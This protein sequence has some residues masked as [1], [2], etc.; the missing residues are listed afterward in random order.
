MSDRTPI[1][2]ALLG[3]YDKTGIEELAR[4]LTDAGGQI[5]LPFEPGSPGSASLVVI[6]DDYIPYETAVA[7]SGSGRVY[8]S[9][10]VVDDTSGGNG[11]GRWDGGEQVDLDITLHNGTSQPVE[12]IT[13]ALG[14]VDGG[15]ATIDLTV[16]GASDPQLLSLGSGRA[17]PASLPATYS[18]SDETL[19]GRPTYTAG[20][21]PDTGVYFWLD[22]N[23]WHVRAAGG[24]EDGAVWVSVSTDGQTM[25]A[26]PF[27]LEGTDSLWVGPQELQLFSVMDTTECEDGVNAVFGDTLGLTVVTAGASYGTLNAGQSQTQSFTVGSLASVPDGVPVYLVL[28][29][30]SGGQTW[31][32]WVRVDHHGPRL[33]EYY[34]GIDDSTYTG[35]GN[36][37]AEVGETVVLRSSILNRGSG[38]APGVTAVLRSLSG[39]DISD[40]TDVIGDVGPGDILDASGGFVFTCLSPSMLLSLELTD[41]KGR[42]WVES[43]ELAPPAAPTGLLAVPAPD[44]IE[45]RWDASA[46]TDLV[47]YHVYRAD[48]E[49]SY[50]RITTLLDEGTAYHCDHGLLPEHHYVYRVTA[51]DT[52]G[53]ESAPSTPLD[54]WSAAPYMSGFPVSSLNQFFSSPVVGDIDADNDLE[55]VIG[56]KDGNVYAWHHTGDLVSGWPKDTGGEVWS[57]PSL[58]Q[59][60]DDPELVVLSGTWNLG[61]YAWNHDGSG[62]LSPN[63]LFAS[64]PNRVRS[65]PV[66]QDVDFDGRVEVFAGCSNGKVYAWN[67]DGTGYINP[68]GV[69]ASL[70]SGEVASSPAIADVDDDG[71]LEIF[72]GSLNGNFYGWNRDGTGYINPDGLFAA[73]GASIWSS[74]SI[75]DLDNNGD[76]EIVVGCHNDSVYAWHHDGNAMANW[77]RG[78][79]GEVWSSPALGDLDHDG[80]LEIVIGSY[81]YDYYAWHH[82]GSGV[83]GSLGKLGYTDAKIW[84]SAALADIDE[85]G[86]PDI[87]GGS[88]DGYLYAWDGG[89]HLLPGWPVATWDGIYGSPAVADLDLDGDLDVVCASYDGMLYVYDLGATENPDRMDWPMFRH[90]AFRTGYYG[91]VGIADVE[92]DGALEII[93]TGLDQNVPNPFNPETR[94]AYRVGSARNVNLAVYDVMGRWVETLAS[95]PHPA[96]VYRVTWRGRNSAGQ[97]VAS[98]VYFCRLEVGREVY[99]TKMVLLK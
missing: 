92:S 20:A 26:E 14:L 53:N 23:G 16:N 63:G 49:R 97:P 43:F 65:C 36:A 77:P 61:V 93:C 31:T 67:H 29:L 8:V 89:G 72:V 78:T 96:G 50:Q 88:L 55:I 58:V 73:I 52:S 19:L 85:N 2:R 68:D 37:K 25:D 34:H 1:R 46:E 12:N 86:L 70:P 5:E 59:L 9:E 30:T 82:D 35:N 39:V 11:D 95:G 99:S 94:I 91:F 62:V 41:S 56:S 98:G 87:V 22:H 4:G 57:S 38:T 27:E 24:F 47:G 44:R 64:T 15:T 71:A 45:I 66:C 75:G 84:G 60:D 79:Q 33:S 40:S 18:I 54:A 32:E 10:V 13:A 83:V 21:P 74:P 51:V 28:D 81:D 80:D 6:G 7:I 3:V 42:R 76:L 90:D 17:H 48:G 69:F